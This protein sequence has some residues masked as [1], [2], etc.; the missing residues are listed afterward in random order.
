MADDY[1]GANRLSYY[2]YKSKLV[3]R[4]VLVREIYSLE[5]G[6]YLVYMLRKDMERMIGLK[7]LLTLLTN[8]EILFRGI[9]KLSFTTEK[10]DG[11][12]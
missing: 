2:S 11:R 5:D 3:V 12:H 1:R 4:A 9:V 8:R 7:I 10:D 6:F